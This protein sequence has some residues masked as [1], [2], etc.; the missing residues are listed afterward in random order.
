MSQPLPQ[1]EDQRGRAE[2]TVGRL[3]ADVDIK[4]AKPITREV[5]LRRAYLLIREVAGSVISGDGVDSCSEVLGCLPSE[6]VV[7]VFAPGDPD[8]EA[9]KTSGPTSNKEH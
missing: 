6:V 5:K 1:F 4:D 7:R 2:G 3:L 9:S 8:V